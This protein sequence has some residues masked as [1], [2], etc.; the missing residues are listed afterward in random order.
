MLKQ[1]D[2]LI[3]FAAVM[4]LVSL[5]VTILT[6]MVSAL[7]GLRG[8]NLAD[9]LVA[10][11]HKIDPDFDKGEGELAK[12]LVD[13]ILTNPV[14]SD[15]TLSMDKDRGKLE[16]IFKVWKRASTIR[17]DEFLG[18]IRQAA[19]VEPGTWVENGALDQAKKDADDAVK[20][21]NQTDVAAG[22]KDAMDKTK[23]AQESRA[24]F[25]AVKLLHA[26]QHKDKTAEAVQL[27]AAQLKAVGMEAALPNLTGAFLDQAKSRLEQLKMDAIATRSKQVEKWFDAAQDRAQQ[28]FTMHTRVWT[29]IFAA[30]TAFVL[31]LDTF[32]LFTQLSTDSD[33]RAKLVNYS[34]TTLQKKADEV[35]TNTLSR[36]AIN[37]EAIHQLQTSNDAPPALKTNQV[38]PDL[39]L[40]VT[41]DVENWLADQGGTNATHLRDEFRYV[42]QSIVKRN[43]D[44]A[45]RDFAELS[46]S[47]SK[48][49][50]Q[51][52]PE[53]YPYPFIKEGKSSS[54]LSNWHWSKQW[55]W[56]LRRLLG[57]LVSAA[58]LSLG[59]PFW[60][61]NLKTLA[62]LRPLLAKNIEEEDKKKGKGK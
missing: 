45:G 24:K 22:K 38:P 25:A 19:G 3:G 15:S 9:A 40:D 5:L 55:S 52:L 58:L 34:Q 7:L 26:L 31:Q 8:L 16:G 23:A 39:R 1:L 59:A 17:S 43:Y 21:A 48:T 2:I 28:W 6:Q 12:E 41:A 60:F 13:K 35:F 50:F 47:F 49:G 32:R 46:D 37:L 18:M 10:M 57:I 36:A 42:E 30:A 61:N 56:P 27:K 4:S 62:S 33:L 20:A 53:P 51:L 44:R 54:C 14:I 11:I 29:V